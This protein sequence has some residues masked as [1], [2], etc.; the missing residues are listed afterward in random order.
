MGFEPTYNNSAQPPAH[1][2]VGGYLRGYSNTDVKISQ[3]LYDL[4]EHALRHGCSRGGKFPAPP[5]IV[6]KYPPTVVD[7]DP[8]LPPYPDAFNP[9]N[10]G[11]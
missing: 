2:D 4:L 9:E 11:P 1:D 10:Y 8:N 6:P 3:R 5:V 7:Q